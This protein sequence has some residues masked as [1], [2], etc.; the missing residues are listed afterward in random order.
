[1][2]VRL[3][4]GLHQGFLALG[5]VGLAACSNGGGGGSGGAGG[6]SAAG[7]AG[8]MAGAI[9]AAGGRAGGGAGGAAGGTAGTD[10]GN[11]EA[12]ADGGGDAGTI[13][14]GVLVD[15]KEDHTAFLAAFFDGPLPPP[16]ALDV[17]QTQGGCQLLVPRLFT[18][19]AGC[20]I[21]AT[22]T[23]N[24][25]CTPMPQSVNAGTLQVRGLGGSD[26]EAEPT[27]PT[28]LSYQLVPT[29]PAPAC[30][31]GD[32]V[33]VN[34]ATFKLATRCIDPLTLTSPPP[35]PVVSGQAMR[36]AW[37]APSVAGISR[38]HI[39]L[40]ISHHGGFKGQIEC[41]V[42]DTGAFEIPE[43]LITALIKLGRAG[44]PTVKVTRAAIAKAAAQPNVTL[45]VSSM[46]EREVDT[47]VISCG[48]A[49]SPPCPMGKTCQVD[50]TCQ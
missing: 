43:P 1:M 37:T 7:G 50:F 44:Y 45:K 15:F 39:E 16:A 35:I 20:G 38:V 31:A 8:G 25:Q 17:S 4:A 27:A 13:H 9:A 19:P 42:P 49:S 34:A 26:R 11:T 21:S 40:E 22:C 10:A 18:C 32:P 36:L 30:K 3:P 12:G 29:L 28:V 24:N 47:G 48:A 14:G 33:E 46:V 6:G 23:G 2:R 5:L 41:D